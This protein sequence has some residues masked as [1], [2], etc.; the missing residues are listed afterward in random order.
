MFEVIEKAS[1]YAAFSR[2][3]AAILESFAELINR[4]TVKAAHQSLPDLFDAVLEE[5]GYRTM[6]ELAG[7]EE[8]D[9]LDNL[10]EFKSAIIE[11]VDH[12]EQPTLVGFLEENALVADVDRYDE[13]ADAVVLMTVHSAKG[14]EFPIV[15]IP[16]FEDGIFP[17]VQT[18][19]GTEDDLEEEGF[20]EDPDDD[21]LD[22][23]AGD[24]A[25]N[26]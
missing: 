10:D 25:E 21:D 19:V 18:T 23:R 26:E 3:A 16:G 2:N 15:I 6:L 14:L 13:T 7:P 11:Y 8:K 5:S 1:T 4:L 20:E 9:R 17:S 12:N 22:Y 24:F